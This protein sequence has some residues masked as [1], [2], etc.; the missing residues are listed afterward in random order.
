MCLPQHDRKLDE[1]SIEYKRNPDR[2][3]LVDYILAGDVQ[4]DLKTMAEKIQQALEVYKV[5]PL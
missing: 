2:S 4:G 3:K 1:L 5:R